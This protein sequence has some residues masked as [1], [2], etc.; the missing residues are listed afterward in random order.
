LVRVSRRVRDPCHTR[1]A[2]WAC[3]TPSGKPPFRFQGPAGRARWAPGVAPLVSLRLPARRPHT[4]GP[5]SFSLNRLG[6][7]KSARRVIRTRRKGP[8][9]LSPPYSPP[10]LVLAAPGSPALP[11]WDPA[12]GPR[13]PVARANP[14][15]QDRGATGC[16]GYSRPAPGLRPRV[17]RARLDG[18][19]A[20]LPECFAHFPHGTCALSGSQVEI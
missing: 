6:G 14:S 20:L 9:Q 17:H 12:C 15:Q 10:R 19:L 18:L 1:G 13:R 7:V 4:T 8:R 3:A 5:R 16:A 2:R 11:K